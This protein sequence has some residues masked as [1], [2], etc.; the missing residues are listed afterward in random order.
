MP[1]PVT[2]TSSVLEPYDRGAELGEHFR[3]EIAATVAAYRRLFAARAGSRTFDVDLWAGRAWESILDLAPLHAE[4]I[5]GIAAGAG[6]PVHE[7]AAINA[8]TELLVA[9]NPTGISECSSVVSLPEGRAPFAVQT[10]DWYHAMS[11]GWFHWRIPH[12]DGRV[13]ETVTEFGMLGKIGVNGYGVG[14]MLNMLHHA[15]DA[16]RVAEGTIG[17]PVHLL[18]R[19]ILDEAQSFDDAWKIAQAPTSASTSLTVLDAEGTAATIELF[20]GGP[21]RLD[22]SDGLL[23]RTNHFVSPEGEA[24]CLAATLGTGS[25]T[26]R[27]K[28]EQAFAAGPPASPEQVVTAM[29]D[30][31]LTEDGAGAICAHPDRDTDPVLWHRTL[32]T[33]ALDVAGSRLDVRPDGPCGHRDS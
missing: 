1:A 27:A 12:P 22:P 11:D 25:A 32:A 18:S 6:R 9:A 20:P 4:E 28:L 24:G 10:W 33:V 26:R 13:V 29:T 16:A 14:V 21:G 3:A 8:R 17:Y 19:R 7:I 15:H 5:A 31:D 23:V 2:F 30:H